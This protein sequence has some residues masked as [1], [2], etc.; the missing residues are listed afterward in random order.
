MCHARYPET[1]NAPILGV[2]SSICKEVDYVRKVGC[3]YA[4]VE[5]D[6]VL[7]IRDDH[8]EMNRKSHEY[9]RKENRREAVYFLRKEQPSVNRAL[10]PVGWQ[11]TV[12]HPWQM[13]TVWAWEKTVVMVKQPGHLTSMKKDRGAGTRV[14]RD[15]IVRD[16][17]DRRVR[18]MVLSYL[19]LVLL[20]L[21]GRRGV[22]KINGEN[23]RANR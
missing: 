17:V 15:N 19:E 12:V 6:D 10:P 23:L 16:V 3:L 13:T 5:V 22:E 14:W 9:P 7:Q 18:C 11:S 20:G 2:P 4:H 21:G 8:H 1:P